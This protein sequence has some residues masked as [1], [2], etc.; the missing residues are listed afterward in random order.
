MFTHTVVVFACRLHPNVVQ[1]C[2]IQ[3]CQ[4]LQNMF[5]NPGDTGVMYL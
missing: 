4:L 3:N 2:L 1:F 5:I